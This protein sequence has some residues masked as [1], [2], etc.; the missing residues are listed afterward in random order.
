MLAAHG[1]FAIENARLHEELLLRAEELEARVVD[2]THEAVAARA[3]AER[4]NLAKSEFLSGISHDLRTP[5]NAILGFGQLLQL[6]GLD[7][8]QE[9]RS[10]RFSAPAITCSS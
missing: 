8:E 3:D 7:T 9:E 6:D 4:A 10:T 2:R 1:A 5:L